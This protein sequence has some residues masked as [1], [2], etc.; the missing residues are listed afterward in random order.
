[1]VPQRRPGRGG[2]TCANIIRVCLE[3]PDVRHWL[4]TREAARG[5]RVQGE[6]PDNLTV[7][8]SGTDVDGPAAARWWPLTSTVVT[9]GGDGV[10]LPGLARWQADERRGCDACWDPEVRNVTYRLH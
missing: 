1:M 9:A 10:G 8:A 7:R 2:G 6:I 4:P 3:T 5:R